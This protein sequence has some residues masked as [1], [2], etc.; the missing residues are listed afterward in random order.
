MDL[1]IHQENLLPAP[2]SPSNNPSFTTAKH[3]SACQERAH[4]KSQI[5]LSQSPFNITFLACTARS[6]RVTDGASGF[7]AAAQTRTAGICC[8]LCVIW[9]CSDL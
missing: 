7:C 9:I 2:S 6:A 5:P 1:I 4:M 3:P 8:C